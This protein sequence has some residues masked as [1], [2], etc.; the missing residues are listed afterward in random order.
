[1][2]LT[3]FYHE[4]QVQVDD[5]DLRLVLNFRT[6]DAIEGLTGLPMP[7]I[8]PE[9]ASNSL[10]YGL[11]GKILWGLMREHHPEVTLDQAAGLMVGSHQA[12]VGLAVGDLFRR[13]FSVGEPE[14][15]KGKN[16][17]RRRGASKPS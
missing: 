9:L 12:A 6:L 17:P 4:A 2:T 1:M 8:L 13:A 7:S 5:T 15:A 14:K 11:I 10:G 16:P 3:P